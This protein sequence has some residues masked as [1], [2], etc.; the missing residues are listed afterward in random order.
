MVLWLLGDCP[1]FDDSEVIVL[2][3]LAFLIFIGFPAFLDCVCS[4]D[5]ESARDSVKFLE[6]GF[7]VFENLCG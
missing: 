7:C 5:S 6:F 2:Y 4:L 1:A 3:L